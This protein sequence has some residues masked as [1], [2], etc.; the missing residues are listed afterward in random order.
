M[1]LSSIGSS[2]DISLDSKQIKIFLNKY[3]LKNLA[4]SLTKVKSAITY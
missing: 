2:V 1:D 3:Q 4:E